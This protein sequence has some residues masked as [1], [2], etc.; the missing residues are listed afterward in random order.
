[1]DS[2]EGAA[3]DAWLVVEAIPERPELKK[4]VVFGE[5]DR[6]AA[7][8]AILA[9]NSSSIPTSQVIGKVQHPERVLN[10]HFQMP[11]QLNSVE[12]MS[13]GK[14]DDSAIDALMQTMPR[15]GMVPFRVRRESDGFIFNRIWAAIKRESLMVLEEGVASA[16]TRT[17]CG[18]SSP[19]PLSRRSG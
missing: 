9:S 6:L 14:T 12:L 1:M 3:A 18:R 8:D 7:P 19:A 10:M 2:L 4:T 11:P 15:Y 16:R 17:R 13:C 5:L